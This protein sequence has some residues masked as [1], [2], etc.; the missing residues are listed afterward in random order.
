[1]SLSPP[2]QPQ[3]APVSLP[4]LQF[5]AARASLLDVASFLDR[6][7]RHGQ[8]GDY[9]IA[10]LK[11]ALPQLL[12]TAAGPTRARRILEALSD[13]TSEPI[14]AANIQGAFGAPRP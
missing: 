7:Q 10:A 4:D 12:D 6:V 3:P 13:P 2:V 11:A 8:D 9:R 1:M 5:I 14:P